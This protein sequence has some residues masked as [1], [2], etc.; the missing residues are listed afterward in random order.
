MN[1]VIALPEFQLIVNMAAL[2]IN[3]VAAVS[4]GD[5]PLNVVQLLWV[6]LIMDTLGALTLATDHLMDQSNV[7]RRLLLMIWKCIKVQVSN[8]VLYAT[9][10]L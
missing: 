8:M 6:N 9:F 7:G 1:D 5:V 2:V 4:S 10:N 3:V